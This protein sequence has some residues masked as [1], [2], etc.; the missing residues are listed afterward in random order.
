[1]AIVR[2]IF[3]PSP[4]GAKL[5]IDELTKRYPEDTVIKSIWLPA[6]RASVQLQRGISGNGAA[7]AIEQLQATS[8]YETAA[9]FW[10]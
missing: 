7:Q 1:M 3:R 5:L 2:H 9:E 8:R 10:L 4:N 6:I